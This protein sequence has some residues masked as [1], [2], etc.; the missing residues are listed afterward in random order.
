[1]AKIIKFI[2]RFVCLTILSAVG[3]V[4]L[5]V[6]A[7]Y[8]PPVQNWAKE[9]AVGKIKESTGM[10][11][12]IATFRLRPPLRLELGGVQAV[13]M[14]GD[15]LATL[16]HAEIDLLLLPLISGSA[17]IDRAEIADVGYRFNNPDSALYFT[18]RV[19]T[20]SLSDASYSF[21][22]SIIDARGPVL[23]AGG[24]MFLAMNDSVPVPPDT[25]AT[26]PLDLLILAH[27]I[28]LRRIAYTMT[29]M[30]LIDTLS[31][32]VPLA[33]LIDG[34]VDMKAQTVDAR[35]LAVD[36][37]TANY[38]YPAV[39]AA[40]ADAD[41]AGIKTSLPWT[42]TANHITLTASEAVYK[43]SGATP[44]AGLDMDFLAV[45]DVTVEVDSFYN[46]AMEL[47][48]PLRRLLATE[49]CGLSLN[50]AGLFTID[51]TAMRADNFRISTGRSLV[52]FDGLMGMGNLAEQSNLPLGLNARAE[53][54]PADVALAFPAAA[55]IVN[56]L[57]QTPLRLTTAVS[58]TS[59]RLD[60]DTLAAAIPTIAALKAS[61]SVSNPFDFDHMNGRIRLDG[62]ISEAASRF[63]GLFLDPATAKSINV[64]P[65]SLRGDINYKPGAVAGNLIAITGGGRI[66][67][68]A[69]WQMKA[70][71]YSG[72]IVM[73]RFP[74]QTFMPALGVADITA[75]AAVTG[76]GYNPL[77]PSTAIEA[78]ASIGSVTLNDSRLTNIILTA[79][80]SGGN[81]HGSFISENQEAELDADFDAVITQQGY[82]WNVTGDIHNL[83]LLALGLSATPM[84]GSLSLAT[85]GSMS[86][87]IRD[88]DATLNLTDIT[89]HMGTEQFEAD[90]LLMTLDTD[91][92]TH[93]SLISGDLGLR[94]EAPVPLMTMTDSLSLISAFI[95]TTLARKKIDIIRLQRLLPPVDAHLA[96]GRRN[97]LSDYLRESANASFDS[98]TLT[99]RNDSLL[100]FR[101]RALG[102]SIG[103]NRLDTLAFDANQKGK[104]LVMRG[105]LNERPGTLDNFAHVTVNGFISAD[106][107]SV[108]LRQ[109]DIKGRTGFNIGT[110]ITANDSTVTM[111]FV[112]HTP[113]I[114]YKPWTINPDNYVSFDFARKFLS[115]DLAL[116]GENSAVK[117]YTSNETH[118]AGQ[119][120]IMVQLDSIHLQDWLSIS[121]FAPPIKG[122]LGANLRFHLAKEQITGKGYAAL[123]NLYYGRDR[124][125]SFGL[126]LDISN[127]RSGALNANVGLMVD[128][129]KVITATGAL[130]DST[131]SNPF[132]LDFSMIRFPLATV[133]PFLPK[134]M[135]QL[136]G[137]LS[138]HMD[139]TGTMTE[140]I[141]N[142]KI[143]FDSTSCK[144]GMI[145]QDFRFTPDSIPVDSN[146]IRFDNYQIHGANDNPLAI[147]GMVDMRSL[148]NPRFDLSMTAADMQIMNSNR[149]RGA[150]AYGKAFINLDASVKGNMEFVNVNAD[151]ALLSG[152]NLTYVMT[153]AQSRLTS[154]STGDMVQF[155]VFADSGAVAMA[156]TVANRM[157]INVEARLEIQENTTIGVDLSAN[158]RDRVQILGQGNLSYTQNPMN[159][160]RLTGRYNINSGFVR[161]S[162]PLMSEKLF[163][164]QEGS[165]VAFNGDMMN[166]LLNI[167]AVDR[168]RC[169]VTRSGEDSRLV[170]F[171]VSVALSGTLQQMDVKFDLSTNDDI[172]IEDELMSMS[173][174]QRANQAM[175]L[176]LYNVYTGSGTR[177]ATSSLGTNQ[178]YSFLSSQL[179]SWMA[180]NIKGVDITFGIDQYDTSSGGNSSTATSYS[181]QVS[182]TLF[183]DRFKIIVGGNYTTDADADENFEQNLIS[184]ISFEYMLNRSGSM[185]VRI[186]RHTGYE[187][188]LEGEITSTGV[189][190]VIKRKLNTLRNLFRFLPGIK[191]KAVKNPEPS[192]SVET[193]E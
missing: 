73:N 48:V 17:E 66:D 72:R 143:T 12:S 109:S 22:R 31:A 24:R 79:S 11:V 191:P 161:Y 147:N 52:K 59:G 62:N 68:D 61:G 44:V 180:N 158:G 185:F 7:L 1:M 184:D 145:G 151:V 170:N 6:I 165:Y 128:S 98:I 47:R 27:D 115:A 94:L 8:L 26:K 183:N 162:P 173:P 39:A 157:N 14:S 110:N 159:D 56:N 181:Y 86:S 15:T 141:F 113:T 4:L 89:W 19:D 106:Q 95:D 91:S 46:R 20:L 142:G 137:T 75:T 174:E 18:A 96:A 33:R 169:N 190:F 63:K 65:I 57:R 23:L 188:I 30:P 50:A 171:D 49:R 82:T 167:K 70:E 111:R 5:A 36:S 90:T 81:A 186:F 118:G 3:L 55:P 41:T 130:N 9:F 172:S 85:T 105:S 16:G 25:A 99:L 119:E 10:D 134:E 28:E 133:N 160:G 178:L 193:A 67:L 80:L 35:S 29:M 192:S 126:D 187:S 189:G 97:C 120:D 177:S 144:V 76:H 53:I 100:H 123:D 116:R 125:G 2:T 93:A 114:A 121:P 146:R 182:K 103:D 156:D 164:F 122:D 58:G 148:T 149:A 168:M 83:D 32:E 136:K 176:L 40:T 117:L 153:D 135:A 42:V 132:L 84:G 138:G 108:F 107:L 163:N 131:A 88:I 112:P 60:I 104:Y 51:S 154:Q 139:I 102:V 166:P 64:P 175:N 127:S 140:P 77:K 101:A 74:I 43:L 54:S 69:R 92:A 34:K 78:D 179:N 13:E 129:V 124:V 45:H 21:K 150:D 152:S 87:D 155:V 71:G 37:V 38:I